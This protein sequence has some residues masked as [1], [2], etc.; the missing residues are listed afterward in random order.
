MTDIIASRPRRAAALRPPLRVFALGIVLTALGACVGEAGLDTAGNDPVV[1]TAGDTDTK[2][3]NGVC[4]Q[5]E[6][7]NRFTT[8]IKRVS[9]TRCGIY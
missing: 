2:Y 6:R 8:A 7:T 1:A 4:F 5:T 9:P 3:A